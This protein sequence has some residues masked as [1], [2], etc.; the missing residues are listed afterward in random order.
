MDSDLY[1]GV[2]KE[3][4]GRFDYKGFFKWILV[5]AIFVFLGKVVWENWS[6]VKHT[7]FTLKLF[8][9][10]LGTLL[11]AISYFIQVWA[12]YLITHKTGIAIAPRET[13]ESWFYSQLGKYLPGKVW[14]LLSR[15]YFYESRGKSKKAISLALYFETATMMVA[16][17]FIFWIAF[18]ST[19]AMDPF[20]SKNL[21]AGVLLPFLLT[22]V[23][24]HP[25]VIEKI[26][27]GILLRLKKEPLSLSI[28]YFD[29]LK[30]L[31]ICIVA[32]MAGGVGFYLFIDSVFSVPFQ[33]SIFLTGALAIS[34]TLGLI[35]LFA[36]GGLGVREGALVYL[37][38]YMMPE[39]VGVIL[40]V[41]TR[42]WMTLIEIGLIGMVYLFSLLQGEKE[43]GNPAWD[44]IK[45]QKDQN[46]REKSQ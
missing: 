12:W 4:M 2:D 5:T 10:I 46:R 16:A 8:P 31:F 1:M 42:L 44:I 13:I 25:R 36:P 33:S 30:I 26:L 6:Q 23:I 21:W 39:A 45:R 37:L 14:L 20:F 15:F 35:A 34:S 11:F 40:S 3:I 32:W 43:K 24:L 17:G 27:N 9:F 29:V 22:L 18:L 19:E 28:S 41:L 7:P 38:S